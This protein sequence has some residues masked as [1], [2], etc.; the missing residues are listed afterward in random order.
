ML[1]STTLEEAN[2]RSCGNWIRQRSRWVKGYMQTYLVHMRHPLRLMREIGSAPFL[3]FQFMVGGRSS[4]LLNPIFWV[5]TTLWL[6]H[7]VA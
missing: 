2:S 6:F 4:S 1:D 7:R 3:S 5:L